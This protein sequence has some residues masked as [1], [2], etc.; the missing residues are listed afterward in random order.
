MESSPAQPSV[1]GRPGGGW[2]LL[3]GLGVFAALSALLLT[4]VTAVQGPLST[5]AQVTDLAVG[6]LWLAV[7]LR[8]L[9]GCRGRWEAPVWLAFAVASTWFVGNLAGATVP[10]VRALGEHGSLIHRAVLVHLLL[11]LP[12]G[13]LQLTS[14][15][16]VAALAY[17]WCL[18]EGWL[19]MPLAGVVFGAA[20]ALVA[21]TLAP[22]RSRWPLAV[23]AATVAVVSGATWLSAGAAAP[24]PAVVT[25]DFGI[26]VV[27]LLLLATS[28]SRSEA[29]RTAEATI[30]LAL[31]PTR[32]VRELLAR[33][34]GD[35]TLD[36]AY[37]VAPGRWVDEAG[38]PVSQ[39]V[40][41]TR[42][43]VLPVEVEGRPR[44]CI[45]YDARVTL[46]QLGEL[47]AALEVAAAHATLRSLLRQEAEEA[48]ASRDR[49]QR[50]AHDQRL[51]LRMDFEREVGALV[52]QARSAIVALPRASGPGSDPDVDALVGSAREGFSALENELRSLVGGLGPLALVTADLGSALDELAIRSPVPIEVKCTAT[53]FEPVVATTVYLVCAEAVANAVKHAAPAHIVLVVE[54]GEVGLSIVVTD[55]GR[56]GAQLDPRSSLALR[57]AASGGT[58]MVVSPPTVGTTVRVT[59]PSP[60]DPGPLA[61]EERPVVGGGPVGRV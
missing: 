37:L 46:P 12:S 45:S 23:L 21:A 19:R 52:E 42:T 54:T 44:A 60:A 27:A 48:A 38:R 10:V 35:P 16:L 4:G 11:S 53:V 36:V 13:R 32:A 58:L 24:T 57:V 20:V 50:A 18:G 6:V 59:L 41:T 14:R 8:L 51:R 5:R 39:P 17:A 15:R 29:V 2:A 47:A 7:T 9:V 34:V 28:P 43:A 25:Y 49:L 61:T 3:T 26:A 1:R 31:G 30:E 33:A 56:G 55:D 22:R 40:M